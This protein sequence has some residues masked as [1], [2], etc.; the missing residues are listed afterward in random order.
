LACDLR[1]N[2]KYFILVALAP[3]DSGNFGIYQPI[4]KRGWETDNKCALAAIMYQPTHGFTEGDAAMNNF[5]HTTLQL[6]APRH[7][8]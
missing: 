7:M 6:L 4:A 8:E 1:Y 3:L 5:I 2:I